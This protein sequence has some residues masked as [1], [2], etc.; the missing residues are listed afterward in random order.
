MNK[1][2]TL[3]AHSDD[4]VVVKVVDLNTRRSKKVSVNIHLCVV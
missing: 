4:E 2:P 3:K 1:E